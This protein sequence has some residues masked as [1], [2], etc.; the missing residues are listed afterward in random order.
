MLIVWSSIRSQ[1]RLV[2]PMFRQNTGKKPSRPIAS[3]PV[4]WRELSA[5][6]TWK[7]SMFHHATPKKIDP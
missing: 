6:E 1:T 5:M 4:N 2:E 7:R 3:M